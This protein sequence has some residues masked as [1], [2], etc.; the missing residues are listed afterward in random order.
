MVVVVRIIIN[1]KFKIVISVVVVVVGGGGVVVVATCE[2]LTLNPVVQIF[3]VGFIDKAK[4]SINLE[5]RIMVVAIEII[6]SVVFGIVMVVVVVINC[7]G[8]TL[9]C[10]IIR[11]VVGIIIVGVD[12][13][14]GPIISG[15]RGFDTAVGTVIIMH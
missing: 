15:V 7:E 6:I 4:G 2:G 14:K 8:P 13:A 10:L 9:L 1:V 11:P 5:R 3:I 12:E